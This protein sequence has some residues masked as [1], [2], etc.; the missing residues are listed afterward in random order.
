MS[1][2]K[3]TDAKCLRTM[4]YLMGGMFAV[5]VSLIFLARFVVY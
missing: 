5:F 1:V 3:I 4:T 2:S